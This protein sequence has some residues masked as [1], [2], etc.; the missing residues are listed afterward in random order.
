MPQACSTVD[1]IVFLE[2]RIMAGGQA[3]PPITVRLSVGELRPLASMA[4]QHLPD[5]GHAGGV[6]TFSAFDQF[7]DRLAIQRR[8]REHQLAARECRRSTECPRR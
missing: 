5:G 8:A 1:A 7:V 3:E 6:V 4:Q 2:G